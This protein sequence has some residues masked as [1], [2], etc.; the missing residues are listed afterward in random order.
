M[1]EFVREL[2]KSNSYRS[3]LGGGDISQRLSRRLHW[4]TDHGSRRGRFGVSARSK[5]PYRDTGC[6]PLKYRSHD[7]RRACK[8]EAS[9]AVRRRE[10]FCT[11]RYHCQDVSI[12]LIAIVEGWSCLSS[13][14]AYISLGFDFKMKRWSICSG[15]GARDGI[16]Q[17]RGPHLT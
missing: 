11:L 13:R 9:D 1:A 15:R 2:A 16:L 12:N 17:R 7:H 6:K 3:R 5:P 8:R 14:V 4:Q 10:A